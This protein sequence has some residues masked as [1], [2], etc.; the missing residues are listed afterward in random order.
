[1]GSRLDIITDWEA[2]VREANYCV[3]TLAG[4]VG[5]SERQLER[6]FLRHFRRSPKRWV[7]RL[8]MNDSKGGLQQGQMVKEVAEQARFK[9]PQSFTRA[10]ERI[11][12]ARPSE[13]RGGKSSKSK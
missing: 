2:L 13:S 3:A 9:H 5:T 8:R 12:G 10:F 7:D 1:M 4:Q 11:N 6:H